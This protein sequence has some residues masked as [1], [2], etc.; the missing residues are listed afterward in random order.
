[1]NPFEAYRETVLRRAPIEVLL[2]RAGEGDV[3][4]LYRIFRARGWRDVRTTLSQ[5]LGAFE[6]ETF[7]GLN[8]PEWTVDC[9]NRVIDLLM[10]GII[11]NAPTILP[12]L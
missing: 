12:T 11:K 2:S 10:V 1:M 4:N 7:G 6:R 9:H 8:A 3:K 5:T